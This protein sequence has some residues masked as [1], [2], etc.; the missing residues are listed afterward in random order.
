MFINAYFEQISILEN[1]CICWSIIFE[2]PLYSVLLL[3]LPPPH[4][5]LEFVQSWLQNWWG[6]TWRTWRWCWRWYTCEQ[7]SFPNMLFSSIV[8]TFIEW[9][10]DRN[11]S[12]NTCFRETIKSLQQHSVLTFQ[13]VTVY[14]HMSFTI[15]IE[16]SWV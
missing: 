10:F 12:F 2:S 16:H 13:I 1:L 8:T 15:L 4:L 6:R 3:Y 7:V 11:H 9:T 14:T 5:V